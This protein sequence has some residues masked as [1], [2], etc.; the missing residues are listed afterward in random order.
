MN[1]SSSPRNPKLLFLISGFTFCSLTVSAQQK[2]ANKPVATNNNAVDIYMAVNIHDKNT[3][4]YWKNGLV[5]P[6]SGG[7]GVVSMAVDGD[8]VYMA[9]YCNNQAAYWKNGQ[10]HQ[11]TNNPNIGDAVSIMT[12]GGHLYIAGK[13]RKMGHYSNGSST[14]IDIPTVW[15]DGTPTPLTKYTL[16]T[17][18]PNDN[19]RTF[20]SSMAIDNNGDVYI[21][22]TAP[23]PDPSIHY[24]RNGE[25]VKELV[26]IPVSPVSMYVY[27]GDFYVVGVLGYH[28]QAAY[29][30]WSK[31]KT[32]VK[33]LTT[34]GY[35]KADALVVSGDD[36]YVA[37][38]EL[39]VGKY[40]KNG[41]PVTLAGG[42][43]NFMGKYGLAVFGSDVYVTGPDIDEKTKC[44]KNGKE[45]IVL[46]GMSVGDIVVKK[47]KGKGYRPESAIE[48]VKTPAP[49]PK[50]AQTSS[51][52]ATV[53]TPKTNE[54]LTPKEEA[55]KF[56]AE[57]GKRPGVITTPSGLQVEIKAGGTGP[58]PSATDKVRYTYNINIMS[59]RKLEYHPWNNNVDTMSHV[60]SSTYFAE[61]FQM[62]NVG[63]KYKLFYPQKFFPNSVGSEVGGRTFIYEIELLEIVK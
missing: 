25:R 24:W 21:V 3:V 45:F 5:V 22:G 7:D 57:N 2:Q 12:F 60:V 23:G 49:A 27:N 15:K 19:R 6:S 46:P 56:L 47:A 43:L 62:M 14:F 20:V 33:V 1:L 58:R 39:G 18:E 26:D 55:E 31:G 42:S 54:P 51:S 50:P 9:G 30:K 63:G 35:S 28:G 36:V 8:D 29:W 34:E 11:L 59:G 53:Q 17:I 32:E 40:W 37:G 44:W 13:E 38:H 4:G 16:E 41:E 10:L 52:S 48:E 61:G